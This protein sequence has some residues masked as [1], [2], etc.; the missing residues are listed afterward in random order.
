MRVGPIGV[1]KGRS[2][3]GRQVIVRLV[4]QQG[5]LSAEFVR[6][7]LVDQGAHRLGGTRSLGFEIA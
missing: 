1:G 3:L 5:R 6:H 2:T 7:A 4:Q